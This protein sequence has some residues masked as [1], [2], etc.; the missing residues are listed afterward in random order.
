M[1]MLHLMH[2][3]PITCIRRDTNIKHIHTH[4]YTY[5]CSRSSIAATGLW[6]EEAT[7]SPLQYRVHST[8]R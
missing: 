2:V 3:S 5:L 6:S 1:H 7:H 8:E 4:M